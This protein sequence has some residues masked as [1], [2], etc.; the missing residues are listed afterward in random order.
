MAEKQQ[1]NPFLFFNPF[2][3]PWVGNSPFFIGMDATPNALKY[4]SESI[5]NSMEMYCVWLKEIRSFTDQGFKVCR[6][7][8]NGEDADSENVLQAATGVC[9]NMAEHAIK[10]FETSSFEGITPALQMIKGSMNSISESPKVM[11]PFVQPIY[12][13]GASFM[14][15]FTPG[16]NGNGN[17]NGKGKIRPTGPK[18]VDN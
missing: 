14:T 11:K 9:E 15:M 5:N 7:I 10:I 8:T 6:K 18:S 12:D 1:A 13:L 17:G 16:T 3:N 4:M 2:L